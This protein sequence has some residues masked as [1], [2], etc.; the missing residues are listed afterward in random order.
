MSAVPFVSPILECGHPKA[1]VS[2]VRS[3]LPLPT[4]SPQLMVNKKAIV[5]HLEYCAAIWN[6]NLEPHLQKDNEAIET[7]QKR[8]SG[9][10]AVAGLSRITL[11]HNI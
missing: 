3:I 11:G 8:A 4:P 10:P 9:G 1:K 7:I 6:G 5:P 2:E